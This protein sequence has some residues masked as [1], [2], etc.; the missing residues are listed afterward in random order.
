MTALDRALALDEL[1]ARITLIWQTAEARAERPSVLDEV[2]SVVYVLAG[3]VYDVLPTV[4]RAV[5]AALCDAQA[6]DPAARDGQCNATAAA[7]H[8]DVNQASGFE[9]KPAS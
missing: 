8:R 1:R 2:Q 9:E 6:L 7:A 5:D 4:Q 3:T